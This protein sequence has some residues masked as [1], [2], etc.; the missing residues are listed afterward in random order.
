MSK[1]N[2]M[3]HVYTLQ[4]K[5]PTTKALGEDQ[6]A[7]LVSSMEDTLKTWFP[8]GEVELVDHNILTEDKRVVITNVLPAVK[9]RKAKEVAKTNE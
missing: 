1:A 2:R 3:H 8:K 9:P 7:D 4:I 5:T 6:V